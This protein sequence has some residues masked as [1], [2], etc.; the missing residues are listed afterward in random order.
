M[1]L[2]PSTPSAITHLALVLGAAPLAAQSSETPFFTESQKF[3]ASDGAEF[4]AF[5]SSAS[6]SGN[7]LVVG[8]PGADNGAV[9]VFAHNGVAWVETDKLEAAG[10]SLF[11]RFGS[12]VALEGNLL[13][14]GAPGDDQLGTDA[15]AVYPYERVGGVWVEG[16]KLVS[17]DGAARDDFGK[18]VALSGDTAVIGAPRADALGH[19]AG[20]AYVFERNGAAWLETQKLL[21]SDGVGLDHFGT[22]AIDGDTIAVGAP[23]DRHM[24]FAP[25]SAYFFARQGATWL[26]QAAF[27]APLPSA[28]DAFGHALA[29]QGNEVFVALFTPGDDD[30]GEVHSYARGAQGWVA[31]ET[32][33][34]S[35]RMD[36]DGFGISLAV[37]GTRC[38]VGARTGATGIDSGVAYVFERPGTRWYEV[39]RLAASDPEFHDQLG[40][41]A[42]IDG[43][44]VVLSAHLDDHAEQ[45]VGSAYA[46]SVARPGT[47][48]C[49]GN[50]CPCANDDLEAGCANSSGRGA[51]LLGVGSASVTGDDMVLIAD[52]MPANKPGLIFA[53]PTPM[54][55]PFGDGK[56]C[57]G[58]SLRRLPPLQSN[59]QGRATQGPGLAA[60]L[61]LGAGT[62]LNFQ[63]WFRD[64]GGPCASG[65]NLSSAY[66]LTFLP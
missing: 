2:R 63:S 27:E 25:G 33:I 3:V 39:Q 9:Y 4:D 6:L 60:Q 14:V 31:G 65:F 64:P 35:E 7:T 57:F 8:S 43:A 32:L 30:R 50:A 13:L 56:R 34:P 61:G 51:I 20:A 15:G 5:G 24:S 29:V 49:F 21:A 52:G 1:S 42:L 16:A 55:A 62:T 46:Y 23:T 45:N 26:E 28:H 40:G 12:A 53:G 58:G 18:H 41:T 10:L 22:V 36:H 37:D 19:N 11:D 47:P 66:A 59:A 38:V 54:E 44:R 17:S 48:Y